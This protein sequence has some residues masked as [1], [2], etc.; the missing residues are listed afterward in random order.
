MFINPTTVKIAW[1]IAAV[2]IPILIGSW[3]KGK[4]KK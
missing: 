4:G 2:V 1:K 3:E